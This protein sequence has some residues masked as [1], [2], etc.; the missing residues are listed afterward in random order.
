[1]AEQQDDRGALYMNR[2]IDR[3][4]FAKSRPLPPF[5]AILKWLTDILQLRDVATYILEA[6]GLNN[7][8]E[9]KD[10]LDEL[11]SRTSD[12]IFAGLIVKADTKQR[13]CRAL[14]ACLRELPGLTSRSIP[15]D[16]LAEW[17][18]NYWSGYERT[19]GLLS[20]ISQRREH[21]NV[22]LLRHAAVELAVRAG[23]LAYLCNDAV[24]QDDRPIWSQD[25]ELK[26]HLRALMKMVPVTL[27]EY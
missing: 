27:A 16:R 15:L 23:A 11:N 19:S 9:L 7:G 6:G 3:W 18:R 20:S 5:G 4:E 14:A 21:A 10:A 13:M 22:P 1:M 8:K 12:D 2:R 26:R 25:V 24:V 17:I